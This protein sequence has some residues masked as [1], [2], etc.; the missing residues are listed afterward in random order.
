[1]WYRRS[2]RF[3]LKVR[4]ERAEGA[5]FGHRRVDAGGYRRAVGNRPGVPLFNPPIPAT[6]RTPRTSKTSKTSNPPLKTFPCR[7]RPDAYLCGL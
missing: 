3:V 7:L 1:M 4:Q 5:L 2:L 6:P